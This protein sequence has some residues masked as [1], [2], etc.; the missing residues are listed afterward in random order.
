MISKEILTDG[1]R[2]LGLPSTDAFGKQCYEALVALEKHVE[3]FEAKLHK[4]YGERL[5]IQKEAA[6]EARRGERTAKKKAE[7]LSGKLLSALEHI[8]TA[9]AEGDKLR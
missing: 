1:D 2:E 3:E 9:L 4:E 5:D 7:F 8:Q 6:T